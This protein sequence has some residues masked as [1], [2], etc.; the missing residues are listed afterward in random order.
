VRP[1]RVARV[2]EVERAAVPL[3]EDVHL[4]FARLG[5]LLE[6]LAALRAVRQSQNTV[7]R[8]GDDAASPARHKHDLATFGRAPGPPE[9]DG[10]NRLSRCARR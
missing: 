4:A 3:P 7:G 6:I 1:G 8:V 10:R 5:D 2:D 9:K